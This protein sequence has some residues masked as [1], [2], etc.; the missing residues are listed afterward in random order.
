V[1]YYELDNRIRCSCLW[2]AG[3]Y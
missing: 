1:I 2:P 3:F